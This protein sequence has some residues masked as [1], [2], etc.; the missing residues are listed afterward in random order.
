M[1]TEP[2]VQP[3]KFTF[4]TEE[5]TTCFT[6][7]RRL[8]MFERAQ[9]GRRKPPRASA[10]SAARLSVFALKRRRRLLLIKVSCCG[11]HDSPRPPADIDT[12]GC[13]SMEINDW[14]HED[15]DNKVFCSLI[16]SQ[17][18]FRI[19]ISFIGRVC[20]KPNKEFDSGWCLV[21]LLR[22]KKLH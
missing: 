10:D 3:N 22:S 5:V 7:P 16:M 11:K 8:C 21:S 9:R 19:R 2:E 20:A 13:D 18:C 6:C 14:A 4:R 12:G 17:R 15:S 1:G